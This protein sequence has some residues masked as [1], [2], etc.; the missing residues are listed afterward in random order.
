MLCLHDAFKDITDVNNTNA[1]VEFLADK[2]HEKE[3]EAFY[4]DV[5]K[6]IKQFSVLLFFI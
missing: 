5:N 1:Y 6:F 4:D 3:K 2:S